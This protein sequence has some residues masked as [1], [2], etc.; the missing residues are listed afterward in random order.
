M[1]ALF[2]L[3]K[4]TLDLVYSLNSVLRDTSMA[5][6]HTT[7]SFRV[8]NFMPNPLSKEYLSSR[9]PTACLE[10]RSRKIKCSG[11][12]NCQ[13]C[14]ERKIPCPGLT[15]RKSRKPSAGI[16]MEIQFE[17]GQ[18]TVDFGRQEPD[19]ID[20]N[21]DQWSFS[22]LNSAI[23]QPLP[24]PGHSVNYIRSS[25]SDTSSNSP[26]GTPA[27]TAS[28]FNSHI[29][30][31]LNQ[32]P[33]LDCESPLTLSTMDHQS[34]YFPSIGTSTQDQW[35]LS[36]PLELSTPTPTSAW[37]PSDN[38]DYSAILNSQIWPSEVYTSAA[39]LISVATALESQAQ[40]L[41]NLAARMSDGT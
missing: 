13:P 18:A 4:A 2:L 16:E 32:L 7:P 20:S 14:R 5:S 23:L 41:R 31:S 26:L 6:K 33:P 1:L 39:D 24:L 21:S 25:I 10:C 36:L 15:S 34:T 8:Y 35:P 28:S 19:E 22:D 9:V 29:H 12:S 38:M 30:S 37:L 3:F 40:C 11:R 27:L 17:S